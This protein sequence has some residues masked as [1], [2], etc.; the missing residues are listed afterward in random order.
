MTGVRGKKPGPDVVYQESESIHEHARELETAYDLLFE[1][2]M[3]RR[4]LST[5][6]INDSLV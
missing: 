2:V 1:E 3:R 6:I 5:S 4:E